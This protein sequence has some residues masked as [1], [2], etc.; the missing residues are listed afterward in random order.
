MSGD[1]IASLAKD[2]A[3]AAFLQRFD[4][5]SWPLVLKCA[6]LYAIPR[7]PPAAALPDLIALSMPAA[8]PPKKWQAKRNHH[9]A[10]QDDMSCNLQYV[11]R[12]L[13]TQSN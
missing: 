6:L 11:Q 12:A 7:I 9:N 8:A 13:L 4:P 3:I 1:P 2:P 5:L 10:I